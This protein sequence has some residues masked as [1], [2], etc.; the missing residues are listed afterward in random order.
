[1]TSDHEEKKER[2]QENTTVENDY[3]SFHVKEAEHFS[4]LNET[5]RVL[6]DALDHAREGLEEAKGEDPEWDDFLSQEEEEE[7]AREEDALKKDG[8]TEE[9]ILS[10]EEIEEQQARARRHRRRRGTMA[11][12]IIVLLF[13]LIGVGY[14][15]TSLVQYIYG[16]VTDDSALRAYDDRIKPVVMQDPAPFESWED[17]DKEKVLMAAIWKEIQS[18][19]TFTYDDTGRTIISYARVLRA[20]RSLFGEDCEIDPS[21]LGD[22]S[23]VSYNEETNAFHVTPYTD[24]TSYTPYT[25]SER[26]EGDETI[27]RVGYVSALDEWRTG[28][29][30]DVTEPSPVKYMLY[31]L[32]TDEEGQTYLAAVRSE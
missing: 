3:R 28:E 16:V 7:G 1:M 22:D 29:N 25:V 12:G 10:E 21:V 11:A 30:P 23:Y 24:T 20:A 19:D 5:T 32:K 8:D 18:D 13:A 31:V 4:S 14:V 15:A 9:E 17:L 6:R 2:G 27:L 26:K